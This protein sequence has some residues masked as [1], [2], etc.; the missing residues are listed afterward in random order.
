MESVTLTE[1]ELQ[2]LQA[3]A[4][5]EGFISAD[6]IGES[7]EYRDEMNP[8]LET[9]PTPVRA[10]TEVEI[11]NL[12]GTGVII[13]PVDPSEYESTVISYGR[14]QVTVHHPAAR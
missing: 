11:A 7:K 4:W 9:V 14:T 1:V 3:A 8:Y 13:P 6:E 2:T 10:L 5:D 12:V